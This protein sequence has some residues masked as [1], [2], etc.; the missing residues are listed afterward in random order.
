MIWEQVRVKQNLSK[1][2][3]GSDHKLTGTTAKHEQSNVRSQKHFAGTAVK[4]LFSLA[5][6]TFH[7]HFIY[8]YI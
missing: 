4:D 7:F 8:R 3:R 6:L 2:K 5:C 1:A